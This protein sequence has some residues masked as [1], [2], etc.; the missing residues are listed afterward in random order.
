[1]RMFRAL[2]TVLMERA[3]GALI[4][5]RCELC[6]E[7]TTNRTPPDDNFPGLFVTWCRPCAA[8]EFRRWGL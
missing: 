7:W 3:F 4:G 2:I 5:H 8:S 6:R 1:M